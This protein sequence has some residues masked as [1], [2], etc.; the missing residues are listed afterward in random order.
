MILFE[1]K[2]PSSSHL[3]WK[4]FPKSLSRPGSRLHV[5]LASV[6]CYLQISSLSLQNLSLFEA[7]LNRL[8]HLL[9]PPLLSQNHLSSHLLKTWFG[10]FLPTSPGVTA[11][12]T[13]VS[14]P[15]FGSLTFSSTSFPPSSSQAPSLRAPPLTWHPLHYLVLSAHSLS[16]PLPLVVLSLTHHLHPAITPSSLA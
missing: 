7:S 15:V 14:K 6:G 8:H 11:R 16:Y 12:S 10:I 4:Q 5:D 13:P 3:F 2:W 9:H 1:K